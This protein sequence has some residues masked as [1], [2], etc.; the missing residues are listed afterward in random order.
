[1]H[2]VWEAITYLAY[3]DERLLLKLYVQFFGNRSQNLPQVAVVKSLQL[4]RFKN[5]PGG[6]MGLQQL[7]DVVHNATE[8]KAH[9]SI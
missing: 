9:I 4:D 7:I 6:G 5:S 3:A 1:M 2:I 8:D